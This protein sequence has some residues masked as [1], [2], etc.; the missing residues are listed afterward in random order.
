MTV[1]ASQSSPTNRQERHW[2]CL[3]EIVLTGPLNVTPLALT[4]VIQLLDAFH[5][6]SADHDRPKTA[7]VEAVLQ[8]GERG[9]QLHQAFSILVRLWVSQPTA[10]S[11]A[12]ELGNDSA[13]E[14]S[15]PPDNSNLSA[16][17]QPGGWG[18]FLL[19]RIVGELA[20]FSTEKTRGDAILMS[21]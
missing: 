11:S 6:S 4:G 3:A 19:E 1:G 12:G 8:A 16:S 7:L 2:H 14:Q 5:V 17:L 13:A 21:G 10:A 15:P 9:R 18:F 20:N